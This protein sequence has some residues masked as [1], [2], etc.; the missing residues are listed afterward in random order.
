MTFSTKTYALIREVVFSNQ[1]NKELFVPEIFI[2]EGSY[3]K[4]DIVKKVDP[5]DR[6]FIVSEEN[7]LDSVI[8]ELI[9]FSGD[10]SKP[11]KA[12]YATKQSTPL[13]SLVKPGHTQIMKRMRIPQHE[14]ANILIQD[15]ANTGEDELER[16]QTKILF[17]KDEILSTGMIEEISNEDGT[18]TEYQR[19]LVRE[20]SQFGKSYYGLLPI[21]QAVSENYSVG[22]KKPFYKWEENGLITFDKSDEELTYE[23]GDLT[24]EA[25]L[26]NGLTFQYSNDVDGGRKGS[27]VK[28]KKGAKAGSK[29]PDDYSVVKANIILSERLI[30]Y[31][32]IS[33]TTM[34]GPIEEF[35]EEMAR[36]EL[37]KVEEIRKQIPVLVKPKTKCEVDPGPVYV[38]TVKKKP[39][40]INTVKKKSVLS[41]QLL[42]A[43]R[44]RT[45]IR[46]RKLGDL[47]ISKMGPVLETLLKDPY[48]PTSDLEKAHLLA[49]LLHETGGFGI[50]VERRPTKCW[51]SIDKMMRTGKDDQVCEQFNVCTEQDNNYFM[52]PTVNSKGVT[53]RYTH[54]DKFRGRFPIQLTHCANYLGFF[55]HL[56]LMAKG[57]KV[58]AMK[59]NTHFSA[60]SGKAG[61]H[62]T[63]NQLADLVKSNKS[64]DL[65]PL[66][67]LL[68]G[69]PTKGLNDLTSPCESKNKKSGM[70]SM[71]IM[72]KSALWYWKTN[73]NCR[74]TV[75]KLTA[76]ADSV[77]GPTKCINGGTN[78]LAERKAYFN[79]LQ[80][81]MKE[82]K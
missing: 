9:V 3:V 17:H 74:A 4:K 44:K 13:A 11:Y 41:D 61:S 77:T 37:K 72:A 18:T 43:V 54:K 47:Y 34:D 36:A 32:N 79:D 26:K 6:F 81:C 45:G 5:K 64:S 12:H 65:D 7:H 67:V 60:S 21:G 59:F 56:D 40:L 8:Y 23:D 49:Q 39:V 28:L 62:C 25:S 35:T 27:I 51:Q 69:N 71:E 50:M 30:P 42:C 68:S 52:N 46:S 31:E 75:S 19:V 73:P 78:G 14:T 80:S 82:I 15:M 38:N 10:G 57:K 70:N 1:A 2:N 53:L 55:K 20:N 48:G 16:V 24:K 33:Q 29:N 58:E 63:D 22:D 76:N 66:G